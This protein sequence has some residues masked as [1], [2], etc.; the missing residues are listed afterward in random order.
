M[1]N[2]RYL[3]CTYGKGMFDDE[4]LINFNSPGQK[5]CLVDRKDVTPI[6]ETKG[7]VKCRLVTKEKKEAI[8]W[9]NDFGDHRP[10]PFRVNMSD[11][12]SRIK[13]AA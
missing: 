13:V 11:L 10:S 5:W 3:K 9:I 8:I 6:D 7:Y 4:Y 12:I 2:L 1:I